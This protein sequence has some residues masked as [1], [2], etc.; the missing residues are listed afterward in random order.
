VE[1]DIVEVEHCATRIDAINRQA[2]FVALNASIEAQ[3]ADG[4]GGTFKV[5]AHELRDLSQATDAASQMVRERIGSVARAIRTAHADLM[6]IGGTDVSDYAATRH[7]LDAILTGMADR[8]NALEDVLSEAMAASADVSGT[9]ARLVTGI[10]FQDRTNQHLTHVIGTVESLGEAI[11]SLQHHTR[12]SVPRLA[13][14]I[15]L[16]SELLHRL[17]EQHTL[18]GVRERFLTHLLDKPPEAATQPAEP[19]SGDVELWD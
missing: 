6:A 12:Q 18:G 8:T 10:Q 15:Q 16:N 5:I 1:R 11:E 17:V 9:I 19:V 14:P 13:R 3:R 2:R 7:Q 4:S